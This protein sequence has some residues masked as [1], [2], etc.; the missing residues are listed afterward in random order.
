MTAQ[1][2]KVTEIEGQKISV[3]QLLRTCHRYHWAARRCSGKDVIE[4]ACGAGQGL[5][6]LK[7]SSKSIVAGDIS[8]E[9]LEAA[10]KTYGTT[11]PLLVFDADS[12]P[13]AD[14]QF[15]VILLFE[16]IYYLPNIEQFLLEA[17]RILRPGGILLIVT[18]NPDLYDF[19]P[20]P[21]S[22]RYL[23]VLE[24][25]TALSNAGFSTQFSALIDT[26]TVSLRQRML[27]PVKSILTQLDLM[28]K[29]MKGK[30][31]MKKLFFGEMA[32][33]PGDISEYP[34]VYDDPISITAD[35]ANLTH[36]VIY[37]S[38]TRED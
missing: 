9:V 17:R 38:A 11:I 7:M 6:L 29:T 25:Q 32:L 35:A 34:V 16:A 10:R 27:R 3:E 8:P 31:W 18:A 5:G 2:V 13:F 20:S 14:A 21:F 26:R 23:G 12:L 4:V 22:H 24:L 33:M 36:K 1:F 15:D 28:P 19:T 37:C 30:Q